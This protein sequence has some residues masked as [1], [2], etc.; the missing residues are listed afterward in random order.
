MAIFSVSDIIISFTLLINAFALMSSKLKNNIAAGAGT[1]LP[2]THTSINNSR[3]TFADEDGLASQ[4]FSNSNLDEK[5]QLL[6]N[7]NTDSSE[8]SSNNSNNN[9]EVAGE[10]DGAAN[11]QSYSMSSRI[12][13]LV[14]VI[15]S[16]SAT[17]VF[18]NIL[19]FILMFFVFP[20]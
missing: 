14:Q 4:T 10:V 15:R 11:A 5:Q 1:G 2:M 20:E 17:I 19:F 7:N 8:G 9:R 18:W 3:S 16:L 6:N 13:R 12:S